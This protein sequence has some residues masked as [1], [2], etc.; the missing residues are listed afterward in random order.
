MVVDDVTLSQ[1]ALKLQEKERERRKR[2][3]MRKGNDMGVIGNVDNIQT[4]FSPPLRNQP[5][6]L[7]IYI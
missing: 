2:M 4:F 1:G 3:Q 5:V 6:S 7:L